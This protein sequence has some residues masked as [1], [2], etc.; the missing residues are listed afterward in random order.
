MFSWE[1]FGLGS[2]VDITLS[3]TSNL[4]AVRTPQE[5]V[6]IRGTDQR[7]KPRSPKNAQDPK[8]PPPTSWNQTVK[9]GVCLNQ[10]E[11]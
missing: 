8:D 5:C 3:R 9:S 10:S 6:G 1:T 11:L 2:Q 7:S 4:K